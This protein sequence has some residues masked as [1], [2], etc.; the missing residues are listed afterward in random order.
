[1]KAPLPQCL[2]LALAGLVL[3][4]GSP[5]A[6]QDA[7][8]PAPAP[9]AVAVVAP[10]PP[11]PGNNVQCVYD[12]M[13]AEDREMALLLLAREI[14]DGGSFRKNSLNVKAVDRLIED[15]HEKCLA[16]FNWSVARS[17]AATGYALAAVLAEALS[18]AMETFGYPIEPLNSYLAENRPR[19]ILKGT[20]GAA[21][22]DKLSLHLK[23]NGWEKASPEELALA[24]IYLETRLLQDQ[25]G[26]R[27]GYYSGPARKPI[28]KQPARAGKAKRGKP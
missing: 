6:A 1:M 8:T 9:A 7:S 2:G 18:Q 23:E 4:A 21:E 16:R 25:A 28:R 22:R 26:R 12:Y 27:F 10:A 5:A 17:D 15:A 3:A 11:L 13:S 14:A 20:I 19:L 24:G